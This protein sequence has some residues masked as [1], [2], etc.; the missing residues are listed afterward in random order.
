MSNVQQENQIGS[1]EDDKVSVANGKINFRLPLFHL[2]RGYGSPYTLSL[3]YSDF[4]LKENYSIWN[5][6]VDT[7]TVGVGF[8]L[9]T[10]NRIQRIGDAYHYKYQLWLQDQAYEL[11]LESAD[12]STGVETYRTVIFTNYKIKYVKKPMGSNPFTSQNYWEV[13]DENG[14]IYIFGYKDSTGIEAG[15][16]DVNKGTYANASTE[17]TTIRK[18]LSAPDDTTDIPPN[19]KAN[20]TVCSPLDVSVR[21][22][23]W[24]G[25]STELTNQ[26]NVVDSWNLSQIIDE[27]ENKVAFSY[28]Q[29]IAH[30]A[31][32]DSS[33]KYTIAS[34]V[35]KISSITNEGRTAGYISIDYREKDTDEYFERESIKARPNGIQNKFTK[36][37]VSRV[38]LTRNNVQKE[39]KEFHYGDMTMPPG[40]V[41]LKSLIKRQLKEIKHQFKKDSSS[42]IDILPSDLFEYYGNTAADNEGNLKLSDKGF[43]KSTHKYYGDHKLY[44][45]LKSYTDGSGIKTV[46][47]YKELNLS[48]VQK[49]IILPNTDTMRTIHSGYDYSI[50]VTK[51]DSL[52]GVSLVQWTST[53]WKRT[54]LCNVSDANFNQSMFEFTE[55]FIAFTDLK[56]GKLYLFCRDE[57]DTGKW[58]EKIFPNDKNKFDSNDTNKV[59]ISLSDHWLSL[60]G[61]KTSDIGICEYRIFNLKTWEVKEGEYSPG[62][63]YWIGC[64]KIV[65]DRSYLFIFK[66]RKES[67]RFSYKRLGG[68]SD[69]YTVNNFVK[70]MIICVQIN[71]VD[72]SATTTLFD[73][74]PTR[75][76]YYNSYNNNEGWM[77]NQ[78]Y[79]VGSWNVSIRSIYFTNG[80]IT[81]NYNSKPMRY[82]ISH[83]VR[84]ST[85]SLSDRAVY[86][87]DV[88]DQLCSWGVA[89]KVSENNNTITLATDS[90]KSKEIRTQE[91]FKGVSPSF[92]SSFSSYEGN[93]IYSCSLDSSSEIISLCDIYKYNGTAFKEKV[94]DN[95]VQSLY[96]NS[97]LL[98]SFRVHKGGR[99]YRIQY[100][101]YDQTDQTWKTI[102]TG[103]VTNGEIKNLNKDSDYYSSVAFGLGMASLVLSIVLL[104]IGLGSVSGVLMT[105]AF[106][107]LAIGEFV[108][109]T[110]ATPLL[111]YISASSDTNFSQS[112][113]MEESTIWFSEDNQSRLTAIGSSEDNKRNDCLSSS[114]KAGE[115]KIVRDGQIYNFVPFYLGEE[116]YYRNL[117]NSTIGDITALN[118]FSIEGSSDMYIQNN[119]IK[120][121]KGKNLISLSLDKGKSTFKDITSIDK[122]IDAVTVLSSVQKKLYFSGNK[123]ALSNA[124]YPMDRLSKLLWTNIE[125]AFA[126][127]QFMNI[128][129]VFQN[130]SYIYLFSQD[131]YEC[132]QLDD[133]FSTSYSFPFK[134]R[135]KIKDLFEGI[136]FD[137]IDCIMEHAD[138]KEIYI[139]RMDK[140]ISYSSLTDTSPKLVEVEILPPKPEGVH[141]T[142][143]TL[144]YTYSSDKSTNT[145]FHRRLD[146]DL[147]S[148]PVDYVVDSV[149]FTIN[150]Q[151]PTCTTYYDYDT[152][153]VA[154]NVASKSGMY[155]NVI[156]TYGSKEGA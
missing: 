45:H 60:M 37:Y 68:S 48:N 155:K 36:L 58:V 23:G 4:S 73:T 137:K 50:L 104:P 79:V 39:S 55:K 72:M 149:A 22:G 66:D 41:T 83:V 32:S 87:R 139:S 129:A 147:M 130:G 17:Y 102:N 97:D 142:Y 153:D 77:D 80:I 113:V 127:S 141:F 86:K 103:D 57:F 12:T 120:L 75:E 84:A 61:Q 78:Y 107:G 43:D 29:H 70:P 143:D 26:G 59:S 145:V 111:K 63:R 25:I 135:G 122:N 42:Y 82:T 91:T 100:Y 54:V 5:K 128:D 47:T 126:G 109:S 27:F 101:Y 62:Y 156:V 116:L 53:G 93:I 89:F 152:S 105:A 115:L 134:G 10:G 123:Y 95:S 35:Y 19:A 117:Q 94:I 16:Y 136:P 7:G 13:I 92:Q 6:E 1:L 18:L 3:S 40:D 20:N 30:V 144:S 46:Y 31:D 74:L 81:I 140:I 96:Y 69:S 99:T 119:E 133:S 8:S 108:T 34:Y 138:S 64:I 44:G 24:Y 131:Q 110:M 132:Y 14:Q 112:F 98:C 150:D 71:H 148:A 38:N 21:W 114:S 76:L 118:P 56:N 52:Q 11:E 121:I 151:N 106:A 28:I 49:Q 88:M 9:N 146:T 65:K 33:K 154:Y 124:T 90:Q 67:R 2:D 85:A 125:N 51:K 15:T